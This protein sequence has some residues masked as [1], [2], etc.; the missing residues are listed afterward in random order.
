MELI[1]FRVLGRGGFSIVYLADE[2]AFGRQLAVK[3]VNCGL[4]DP[5]AWERFERECR[6]TGQ[7]SEH[8]G[9]VTLHAAGRTP[10]GAGYIVME[11]MP[12]GS[13]GQLLRERGALPPAQATTVG[14]QIAEVVA[15]AHEVGIVHRDVKPENILLSRNGD[16]KLADFGISTLLSSATTGMTTAHAFTP[17]HVAPEVLHGAPANRAADVYSVASSLYQLLAGRAPFRSGVD[18]P[19][20][21]MLMRKV[22]ESPPPLPN[23]VTAGLAALVFAGLDRDPQGRPTARELGA[24][25]AIF[26]AERLW[27]PGHEPAFTLGPIV[28]SPLEG[29][30]PS[31]FDS[32]LLRP[33]VAPPAS[34]PAPAPSPRRLR[35]RL[36]VAGVAAGLVLALG[37]TAFALAGRGQRPAVSTGPTTTTVTTV[38]TTAI[39]APTST[40]DAATT[41]VATTPPPPATD[42]PTT[43][44]PSSGDAASS[45]AR[46]TVAPRPVSGPS[47]STTAA[48]ESAA[49]AAP[50]APATTPTPV[51]TTPA[52]EPTATA[53]PT[54]TPTPTA[55]E[56]PTAALPPTVAPRATF[57]QGD[58]N[59][60]G[61]VNCTDFSILQAFYG[62]SNPAADINGD[63]KVDIQDFSI[64]SSHW[65]PGAP[66]SC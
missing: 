19:L 35:R 50:V 56:A 2:P 33:P 49:T 26:P 15:A 48:T 62:T 53:P 27:G 21:P 36:V 24:G 28:A 34:S 57:S 42:P 38:T 63:G 6:L 13:V 64:M 18:E 65:S 43:A 66:S 30:A 58:L 47:R 5:A 4:E 31:D 20:A 37:G 60:D 52:T 12:G 25:L 61:K 29:A 17:D 14:R 44:T 11:Y 7:L 46:G 54:P 39:P 32:T 59:G 23:T 55:T 41:T 40:A 1:N 22:S 3:V 45:A 51:T 16:A 9:V 10:T 8:A